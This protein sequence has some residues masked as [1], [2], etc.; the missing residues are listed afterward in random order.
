MVSSESRQNSVIMLF[1]QAFSMN[2]GACAMGGFGSGR[3]SRT[4]SVEECVLLTLAELRA[5]GLL[6]DQC[7]TRTN[8]VWN[9]QGQAT[10]S[11]AITSDVNCLE[12]HPCLHI[13]GTAYGRSIEHYVLLDAQPMRFGGVR[14][15][16][17]C[18]STGKRCTTLV[19][20]PNRPVFVARMVT[21]LPNLTQRMDRVGRAQNAVEKA[22]KSYR[23]LSKYARHSTRERLLERICT[24]QNIV[25][26]KI[27][28][29]TQMIG[30]Y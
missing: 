30:M 13:K 8:L 12:K 18:P 24:N 5:Y 3:R 1:R 29:L 2:I 4:L 14:W 28:R 7:L 9:C 17:L 20:T 10:A 16:A 26:D 21:K 15:Y 27:M 25:D 19:L 6:K 11:F 23:K 22:E